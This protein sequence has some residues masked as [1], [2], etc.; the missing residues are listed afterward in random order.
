MI[1]GVDVGNT[2]IKVVTD[3]DTRAA[4]AR[5]VTTH[6]IGSPSVF[7][8]VADRIGIAPD[9]GM[10]DWI[11]TFTRASDRPRIRVAA[12]SPLIGDRLADHLL[13]VVPE[14]QIEQI[15]HSSIPIKIHV[16]EPEKVGVDRLLD[17]FAAYRDTGSATVVVDAGSAVTVDWVDDAGAFQGGCILPGLSMQL[18][19]LQRG[20][21]LLPDLD[22]DRAPDWNL[23]TLGFDP[24]AGPHNRH[25]AR[26]T[27]PAKNTCSAILGGV[28]VGTAA[29]IDAIADRYLQ[30]NSN[31]PVL[32]TGGDAERLVPFLQVKS[33]VRE[34]LACHALLGIPASVS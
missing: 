21:E 7:Q 34:H 14:L 22:W 4:P 3:F 33:V 31:A 18:N 30:Y 2:A 17:A 10:G 25:A 32:V 28:L 11:P 12:V 13:G 24:P 9:R 29:A 15:S 27:L 16:D 20:A 8:R 5:T 26:L 6:R 1:V 23:A 19:A